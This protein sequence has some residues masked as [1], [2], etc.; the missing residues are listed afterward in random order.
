M[1]EWFDRVGYSADI[2]ANAKEFG[3][4]PTTLEEWVARQNWNQR[5]IR[6]VQ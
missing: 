5:W 1:L 2:P 4:R 6:A 3:V